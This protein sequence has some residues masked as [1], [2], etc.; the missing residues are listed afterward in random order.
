M[1]VPAAACFESEYLAVRR[2]R[3]FV[4]SAR[5]RRAAGLAAI[6][7]SLTRELNQRRYQR[8][9][10]SRP[11][12]AAPRAGTGRNRLDLD[13]Q[14]SSEARRILARSDVQSIREVEMVGRFF[15]RVSAGVAS[16]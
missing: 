3:R 11:P 9:S 12:A 6:K 14:E 2:G 13:S 15:V 1:L 5:G 16:R 10:G 4:P 8:C 7:R